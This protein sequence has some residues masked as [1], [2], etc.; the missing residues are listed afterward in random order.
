MK[1]PIVF[2]DL[3]HT[4]LYDSLHLLFEKRLGGTLLRPV[5]LDWE[6]C[7]YGRMADLYNKAPSTI[8]QFLGITGVKEE[9]YLPPFS[10]QPLNT[11]TEKTDEYYKIDVPPYGNKAL[12]IEQFKKMDIDYVIA[13]HPIHYDSF[14][15]IITELKPTAKLICQFGNRWLIN[16]YDCKNV[17]ASLAPQPVPE[18]VNAVFYH[19]EFDTD[20]F[21]YKPPVYSKKI[22]AFLH[23]FDEYPDNVFFYDLERR[24]PDWDFKAH[25]ATSRDGVITGYQ[26]IAD[27]MHDSQFIWCVKS[28]G[29]G[30][31]HIIHNAFACG[32][33][34]IVRR[35]YYAGQLAEQLMEDEKT[36]L[37]I[38]G[39]N[40][41]Q[42][43]NKLLE[44]SKSD[45]YEQLSK[46][47]Y[48]KFK[49]VVDYDKEQKDIERFL[50]NIV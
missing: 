18:G 21:C 31:G 42:M 37:Q 16:Q 36:C 28:V 9:P 19:Q 17:M 33:P 44:Y 6:V 46:N 4:G 40:P 26:E 13:S 32:R 3:H 27:A 35:S 10:N 24:L 23:C 5:G 43:V 2:A 49:E 50:S 34:P 11:I 8:I 15:R 1:H 41:E 25:G 22:K 29:D 39:L 20:I 38:D 12:T 48:N 7:G 47:A 14:K 45:K 30:F